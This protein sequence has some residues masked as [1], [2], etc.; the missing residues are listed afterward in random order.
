MTIAKHAKNL[1][2]GQPATQLTEVEISRRQDNKFIYAFK[3]YGGEF[4]H[5]IPLMDRK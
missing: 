3:D 2:A 5:S 4:F 1:N